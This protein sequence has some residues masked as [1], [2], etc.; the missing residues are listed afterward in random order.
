MIGGIIINAGFEFWLVKSGL[1]LWRWSPDL[2]MAVW[3][4]SICLLLMTLETTQKRWIIGGVYSTV[5]GIILALFVYWLYAFEYPE[6]FDGYVVQH[7]N[8]YLF[9]DLQ[10][11]EPENLRSLLRPYWFGLAYPTFN[12]VIYLLTGLIFSW[13]CGILI[14]EPDGFRR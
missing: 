1:W 3:F 13:I 4:I 5:G 7:V 6:T 12:F 10:L 2:S 11:M 14:P 8:S 9:P